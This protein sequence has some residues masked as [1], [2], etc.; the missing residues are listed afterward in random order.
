MMTRSNAADDD[1][2]STRT[3]ST[4]SAKSV[5]TKKKRSSRKSKSS[6][7][8]DREPKEDKPSLE[9]IE[10]PAEENP[11][12]CLDR[13]KEDFENSIIAVHVAK[14]DAL[15]PE[16]TVLNPAIKV[17][18]IDV[19]TG[20]HPFSLQKQ[21]TTAP[22]WKRNS[23]IDMNSCKP[24]TDGW[25]KIAWAFLQ[26]IGSNGQCNTETTARLQLYSYQ[27]RVPTKLSH[28]P[29]EVFRNFCG[30]RRKKYP[31]TLYVNVKARPGMVLQ[32]VAYRPVLPLH[33]EV[34]KL[35][36]D[37]LMDEF[38]ADK[39][40]F[41]SNNNLSTR[42]NET[43]RWKRVP[44]ETCHIPNKLQYQ[45][46]SGSQGCLSCSFSKSGLIYDLEWAPDRDELLSSS[47]D[48]SARIW[49]QAGERTFIQKGAILQSGHIYCSAFHSMYRLTQIIATG[50]D[51]GNIRIWRVKGFVGDSLINLQQVCA[52][53]TRAVN[54]IVFDPDGTKMFS[55][56]SDKSVRVWTCRIGQTTDFTSFVC[57]KAIDFHGV[58]VHDIFNTD[59]N[60][61][62]W[63]LWKTDSGGQPLATIST[64]SLA[65]ISSVAF[66]PKDNYV[67]AASVG[68]KCPVSVYVWDTD[69]NDVVSRV[70]DDND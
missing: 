40:I 61:L 46:D 5:R 43:P 15:V 65:P 42:V 10:K 50:G 64:N 20:T 39:S 70:R 35:G 37:E 49:S 69:G 41:I 3:K 28:D 63:T 8:S 52:G 51:D 6:Q 9:S 26:L 25:H 1:Q 17:H 60:E 14:A 7:L 24:E 16:T 56:S 19:A 33:R 66:H 48:G 38:L 54:A 22:V 62:D 34:G 27:T 47:A 30:Q 57:V 55:A 2:V 11:F 68:L 32:E 31:A 13:K 36:F 53:H 67:A 4:K 44:G 21:R 23:A 59:N 58:K 12:Q 18:F 45:F 29:T